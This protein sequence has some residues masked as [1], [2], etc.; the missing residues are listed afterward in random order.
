MRCDEKTIFSAF[1]GTIRSIE[2]IERNSID[3]TT[4]KMQ[5][6]NDVIS[7]QIFLL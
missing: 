7:K 5:K 4:S 6:L 2:M 3:F 1:V